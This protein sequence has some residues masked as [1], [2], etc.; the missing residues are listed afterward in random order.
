[1]ISTYAFRAFCAFCEMKGMF[2]KMEKRDKELYKKRI[3]NAV[4]RIRKENNYS[5]K[6]FGDNVLGISARQ[7]LRVE[8][9]HADLSSS[10]LMLMLSTL[11]IDVQ[12]FIDEVTVMNKEVFWIFS[13]LE[14]NPVTDIDHIEEKI[15]EISKKELTTSEEKALD[16]IKSF[17]YSRQFEDQSFLKYFFNKNENISLS[18]MKILAASIENFESSEISKVIDRI[19]SNENRYFTKELAHTSIAILLN[20]IGKFIDENNL[21]PE[22]NQ[23]FIFCK[24]QILLYHDY[25]FLPI[26]YYRRALFYFL[27]EDIANYEKNKKKA[28][29][30]A[31]LFENLPLQKKLEIEFSHTEAGRENK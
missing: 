29:D 2:T 12:T 27:K 18:K 1:M 13:E 17:M 16:F 11:Q 8:N 24:E 28:L 31:N 4:K 21:I 20:G 6:E 5:L 14:K 22:L 9:E 23:Y 3:G 15:K 25:Y 19:S 10:N 30:L 7:L 26:F